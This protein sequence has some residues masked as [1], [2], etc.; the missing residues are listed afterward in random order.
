MKLSPHLG[1]VAHRLQNE[2][3][4]KNREATAK[5]EEM[6]TLRTA[7]GVKDKALEAAQNANQSLT[8]RTLKAEGNSHVLCDGAG[9]FHWAQQESTE[10]LTMHEQSP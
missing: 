1:K 2:I 9:R 6:R 4:H 7:V 3:R 5:D 10:L 8:S